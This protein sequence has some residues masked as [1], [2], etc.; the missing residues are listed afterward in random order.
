[1]ACRLSQQLHDLRSMM[2]FGNVERGLS[3]VVPRGNV[4]MLS[5]EELHGCG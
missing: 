1:M 5:Q 3:F 4:G 2:S